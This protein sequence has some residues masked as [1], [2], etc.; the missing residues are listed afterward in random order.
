VGPAGYE[1][2][3]MADYSIASNL[4]KNTGIECF[5]CCQNICRCH[6]SSCAFLYYFHSITPPKLHPLCSDL[7]APCPHTLDTTLSFARQNEIYPILWFL[8]SDIHPSLMM[9]FY[10][11]F[12]VFIHPTL[13]PLPHWAEKLFKQTGTHFPT[14]L[15]LESHEDRWT[16]AG[17]HA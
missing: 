17:E 10:R 14:H 5:L 3:A 4:R 9:L 11:H 12:I 15:R 2:F 16:Y 13:R 1:P 8:D 6:V 7:P